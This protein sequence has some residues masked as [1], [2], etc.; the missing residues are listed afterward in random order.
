[1]STID[2]YKAGMFSKNPY[3]AKKDIEGE[4]VVILD[5]M[6]ENRGLRLISPISRCIKKNEIHELILTDEKDA[7]P[8]SR[9]DKIAYL[10]FM[11]VTQG[12]VLVAGDKV[13]LRNKYVGEIAGFDETHMPNHLNIVLKTDS[14]ATGVELKVELGDKLIIHK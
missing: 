7:G 8:G 2:P 4:L 3:A 10:G 14:R 5:G 6:I 1:M 11:E 13:F 9:V 12:S